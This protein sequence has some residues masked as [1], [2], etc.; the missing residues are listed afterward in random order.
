MWLFIDCL[1]LGLSIV[2]SPWIVYLFISKEKFRQGIWDRLGFCSLP[3]SQQ[4]TIWIHGS[5]VGEIML[6]KSLISHLE[7]ELPETPFVITAFTPTGRLAAQKSFPKHTVL[8]F[9][10]DLSFIVKRYLRVLKPR[11]LII[12]ESEFWPNF[13]Y[14]A[15]TEKIPVL[16]LNGKI[17]EKS[18][19][20][21]RKVP[22]FRRVF[23]TVSLLAVQNG[24]Y[25]NRFRCLG[26][27]ERKIVVTGNM[28]YDLV[29]DPD[30]N[31]K[32]FFRKKFG[33]PD[34]KIILIGGSTHPGED[35]VL[36]SA[37][38]RLRNEGYPLELLIVPRYPENSANIEAIIRSYQYLPMRKTLLDKQEIKGMDEIS[39]SVLIV[40]TIG[41]LNTMYCISDI[42][43]VGGSLFYR[44]SNKGGHNMMEPAILGVALLFG[45]YNFAFQDTVNDL[46][47]AEAAIMVH[48][49]DELY[50][51]LKEFLLNPEKISRLGRS[52]HDVIVQNRGATKRN[53]ELVRHYL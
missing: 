48:D 5:S 34:N 19:S 30:S 16:L 10:I 17:S 38:S 14:S 3:E 29:R 41:E 18:L 47:K 13:I 32:A 21:Y 46:M 49:R 20:L 2:L 51:E 7:G 52:A 45:P 12:F 33:Y 35:E 15:Y 28:K 37:F 4:E 8:Y 26:I 53:F 1:Y 39:K 23:H 42:A 24:E 6:L 43:Y 25:A 22:F 40:D 11:V 50:G 36:M 9:P 31:T 44:G 27:P